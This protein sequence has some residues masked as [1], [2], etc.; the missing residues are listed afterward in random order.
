MFE[1][2]DILDVGI[3]LE[4]NGEATYRK[5]IQSSTDEELKRMLAWMADEE[6]RHGSWFAGLKAALGK[7]G[8]SPFL[9]KMGKQ[10]L[11]D[12][13]GGQSFS[14]REVDFSSVAGPGELAAIFIEFE[15]D[16]VLFYEMI[17]PF[18]ESSEART[19]LEA[20]IAEENRHI[21]RL[22]QFMEKG[23]EALASAR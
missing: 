12:V 9:E 21:A 11:E 4:K 6:A 18:I 10:L 19:Q 17:A 22:K 23:E 8:K 5:A 7:G 16:T 2:K 3:R 14:L 15:K 20:I 13:I 1:T